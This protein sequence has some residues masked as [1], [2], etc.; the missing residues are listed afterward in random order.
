MEFLPIHFVSWA[1]IKFLATFTTSGSV[2]VFVA[3][4]WSTNLAS[5]VAFPIHI[6]GNSFQFL[7][8]ECKMNFVV[9]NSQDSLSSKLFIIDEVLWSF[10]TNN[11]KLILFLIIMKTHYPINFQVSY[12][13]TDIR[14]CIK[15][16]FMKKSSRIIMLWF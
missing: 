6:Y 12:V 5:D 1:F 11:L 4:W 3:Q 15:I 2:P 7:T 14:K 8:K 13:L 10:R 16:Y 9:N